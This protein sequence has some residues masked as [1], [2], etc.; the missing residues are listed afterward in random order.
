MGKIALYLPFTILMTNT[1]TFRLADNVSFT[2]V[3]DEVVLLELTRGH[4]FG[5]NDTGAKMLHA[6]IE[7]A[8]IEQS[9]RDI[10]KNYQVDDEQI[11]RDMEE[12]M[13][14]LIEQQLLVREPQN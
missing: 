14:Q 5:L 12:L 13:E 11:K 6:L 9:C 10:A 7:G 4:Y 2:E 1:P 3:D 8:T